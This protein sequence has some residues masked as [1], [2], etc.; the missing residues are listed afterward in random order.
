MC[1]KYNYALDEGVQNYKCYQAIIQFSRDF[2]YITI[3]NRK[4]NESGT[5][6][7]I[8]TDPKEL[9]SL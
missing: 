9:E 6:Y 4:P 1:Q 8:V 2:K 5:K 3:T 7:A